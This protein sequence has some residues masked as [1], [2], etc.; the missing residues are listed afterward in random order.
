MSKQAQ[1]HDL[2]TTI[3]HEVAHVSPTRAKDLLLQAVRMLEAQAAQ[4][5][6]PYKPV[7]EE[8]YDQSVEAELMALLAADLA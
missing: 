8:E 4:L 1:A 7:T 3:H 2:I 5:G 6:S